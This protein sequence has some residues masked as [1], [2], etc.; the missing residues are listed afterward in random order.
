[1][2]KR[3]FFSKEKK[4]QQ[5]HRSDKTMWLSE[6]TNKSDQ[7]KIVNRVVTDCIMSVEL[8]AQNGVE[9]FI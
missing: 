9:N 5:K 8:I 7:L 2:E 6:T 1:M 3:F 4:K